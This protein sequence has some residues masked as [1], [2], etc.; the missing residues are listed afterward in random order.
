LKYIQVPPSRGPRTLPEGSQYLGSRQEGSGLRQQ[1]PIRITRHTQHDLGAALL[2]DADRFHL[3]IA[4]VIE[5]S[6]DI[7]T[8]IGRA[9]SKRYKPGQCF[10]IVFKRQDISIYKHRQAPLIY[11]KT[12]D[13]DSIIRRIRSER[14]LSVRIANAC[15]IKRTAVYQ[16]TRV[17]IMRVH[18]VADVLGV[19][20][21]DIRPDVFRPNRGLPFYPTGRV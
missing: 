17:P 12:M 2:R 4:R 15:G 6:E 16:W 19:D 13:M 21:K 8:A 7:G 1:R 9:R 14:G 18:I 5:V 10:E 3:P 20:P 11:A